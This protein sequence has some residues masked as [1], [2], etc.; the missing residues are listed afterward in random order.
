MKFLSINLPAIPDLNLGA[1][2]MEKLGKVVIIAGK[3]GAGKSRLLN[4]LIKLSGQYETDEE[5]AKQLN[6]RM[7][8]VSQMRSISQKTA[9]SQNEASIEIL[10]KK[11]ELNQGIKLSE[12]RKPVIVPFVPNR[13]ELVD[14]SSMARTDILATSKGVENIGVSNLPNGSFALIQS[15][16]DNWREA[17]HPESGSRRPDADEATRAYVNLQEII[18]KFLETEITRSKSGEAELFGLPLGK[19]ALSNGQKVILQ[20]CVAIFAQG[21]K[22]GDSILFMDEP[23]NHLH[24][25]VLL[26]LVDKIQDQ[27]GNGQLW[28]ATHSIPL[29]AEVDASSIWWMEN[30]GISKSGNNPEKVLSGLLG[31]AERR[32][33]LASFLDLPFG[34]ASNRFAAECILPPEVV[35]PIPDDPQTRQIRDVVEAYR[36]KTN[37]LRVLDFGA[38]KG[39]LACEFANAWPKGQLSNFEYIAYDSSKK[40][41][42]DCLAAISGLYSSAEGRYFNDL[43]ELRGK[44]DDGSFD[45]VVM[46]N[47]LHELIPSEWGDLFG[48]EGKITHLLKDNGFLLVVEVQQL[49]YGE[50]AHRYGFLILDTAQLRKLFAKT[51]SDSAIF[52][53][54]KKKDGWLKAHLIA[55]SLITRYTSATKDAAIRDLSSTARDKIKELRD[56]KL[57]DGGNDYLAGRWHGFW[58]E[59]F[60]NAELAIRGSE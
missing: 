47:V 44:Y 34:L 31:S 9:I 49:P 60:A 45:L 19:T 24:P 28:I 46:C 11:L 26:D 53:E 21:A 30:N 43:T 58:V 10:K 51:E 57:R 36:Q 22:L 4:E 6:V 3:N 1:I 20:L 54:D 2:R 52:K 25:S 40:D 37:R 56:K 59:Q 38:G 17:T 42:D 16:Q 48:P 12:K 55:R 41:S 33:K 18:R 15:V 27:I 14:P 35:P 32:E 8:H 13:L 29:L 23:E 7:L 50:Q 39:R 5:I